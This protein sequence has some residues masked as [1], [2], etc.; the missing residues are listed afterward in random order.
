MKIGTLKLNHQPRR[1]RSRS[2]A[3]S[4]AYDTATGGQRIIL[5]D[6]NRYLVVC[7][8]DAERLHRAGYDYA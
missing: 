6:D 7:P 8:A 2:L 3:L 4:A 5:G 1:Y